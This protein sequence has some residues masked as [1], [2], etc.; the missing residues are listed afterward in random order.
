MA[1]DAVFRLFDIRMRAVFGIYADK[2]EIK[3]SN[4]NNE[5]K[6]SYRTHVRAKSSNHLRPNSEIVKY[7]PL[8][9]CIRN[10]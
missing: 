2:A 4:N 1:F 10:R 7:I 5:I 3:K 8:Y 9:V 6:L